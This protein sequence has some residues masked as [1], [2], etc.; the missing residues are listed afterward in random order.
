MTRLPLH[1]ART[2]SA[3][4]ARGFSF[5]E[6]L[7]AVMILGVGFIMVAAI[8]PVAIQQAKTSTEET[9]AAAVSRGGAN[10]FEKIAFD[11]IMPA[12]NNVVVGPNFD[13]DAAPGP[14]NRPGDGQTVWTRLRGNLVVTSDH[15]YAWIPFYRRAGTPGPPDP[16][17][18]NP[19]PWSPYAQVFMIPVQVRNRSEYASDFPPTVLQRM[20]PPTRIGQP[21]ITVNIANADPDTITFT[22]IN[23]A[24]VA[25][26]GAYVLVAD[27]GGCSELA[28]Y[29]PAVQSQMRYELQG[30][31]YRLGNP[32]GAAA[33]NGAYQQWELMPGN[34]FEP[35]GF[36]TDNNPVTPKV[37]ISSLT[38]ALV[39]VVGRGAT[40]NT[41]MNSG[42]PGNPPAN[43]EGNGQ[44]VAAY[45]T[46]ISVK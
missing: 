39:F 5:T 10:Y 1:P 40:G 15:R 38:G 8:F 29:V 42:A 20:A 9:T 31:I 36:D 27:V 30:R 4:E 24:T 18:P 34:D 21:I 46:F 45:T 17:S 14:G 7:F 6:V 12:T 33:N 28:P 3:N 44:D 22:D 19:V 25:T 16:T 13:Y 32:R 23:Q 2:R 37:P 11:N 41:S 43:L 35:V 26:E